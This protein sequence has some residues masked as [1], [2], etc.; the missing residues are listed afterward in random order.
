M[1]RGFPRG[2]VVVLFALVVLVGAVIFLMVV[3][4]TPAATPYEHVV[5]L[6]AVAQPAPVTEPAVAP[7]APA[8]APASAE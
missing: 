2:L 1:K 6:H 4:V 3:D 8:T 5:D 7:V